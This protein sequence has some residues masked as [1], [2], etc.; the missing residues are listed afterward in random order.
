MS[1]G[2]INPPN[3]YEFVIL[4]G[5]RLRELQNDAKSMSA[6]AFKRKHGIAPQ[7]YRKRITRFRELVKGQDPI[8]GQ[9]GDEIVQLMRFFVAVWGRQRL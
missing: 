2:E 4:Y 1:M 8:N 5:P 7:E 3:A 9:R 6:A